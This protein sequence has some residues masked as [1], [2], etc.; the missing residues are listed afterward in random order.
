M[1]L[2]G[3]ACP[4]HTLGR[5]GLSCACSQEVG[6]VLHGAEGAGVFRAQSLAEPEMNLLA[7]M[8]LLVWTLLTLSVRGSNGPRDPALPA[9]EWLADAAFYPKGAR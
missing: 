6:L 1:L 5:W 4:A 7:T 8:G 9:V 2:G 3:G